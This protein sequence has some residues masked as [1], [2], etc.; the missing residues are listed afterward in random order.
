[1]MEL[2]S[3]PEAE[4]DSDRMRNIPLP[5][6]TIILYLWAHSIPVSYAK[7]YEQE[8]LPTTKSENYRV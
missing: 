1:M 6:Q 4:R 3:L 2:W 5:Q 7:E 8:T